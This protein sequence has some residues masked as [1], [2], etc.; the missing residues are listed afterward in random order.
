[1]APPITQPVTTN[2]NSTASGSTVPTN[3]LEREAK[4]HDRRY[5]SN[6]HLSI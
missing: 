6:H 4:K 5:V 3:R 1:M 2:S